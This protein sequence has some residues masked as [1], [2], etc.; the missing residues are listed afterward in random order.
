[1]D[2]PEPSGVL[3]VRL[4]I[5]GPADLRARIICSADLLPE[6]ETAVAS[7]VEDILAVVR[8]Y[9]ED[10]VSSHSSHP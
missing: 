4:W 7:S 6:R 2:T 8:D 5:E 10:F 1:M 3:V 9:I